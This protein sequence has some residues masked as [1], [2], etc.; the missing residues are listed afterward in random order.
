MKTN[1]TTQ[2]H[3]ASIAN[4]YDLLW[5][6]S[7]RFQ[8]WMCDEILRVVEL[9]P[10]PTI[11]DVGGGTGIYA[12][13]LLSRYPSAKIAVVDPSMEMLSQINEDSKILKIC[14]PADG[15]VV[16]LENM[17]IVKCDLVL[18]KEAVHH[19]ENQKE[20]LS[21]LC[22]LLGG[23]DSILI[24]MLPKQIQYPLFKS[25]LTRFTELQPDP[26]AIKEILIS[27][28]LNVT[29][30]QRGYDLTIPFEQWIKMIEQR[31]MSLLSTFSEE[32]MSDGVAE[33][34]LNYS[35]QEALNFRDDFMFIYG[36]RGPL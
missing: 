14:A 21:S 18:V 32:E 3:Y 16:E 25:A 8:S 24:I 33:I 23:G 36:T 35:N 29:L 27:A 31:F 11:V 10:E 6:H 2:Q 5:E 15:A 12:F 7:K 30:E 34:R 22:Q 20:T 28:G 9:P 26:N 1:N 17:G 13:A 19:F 4:E